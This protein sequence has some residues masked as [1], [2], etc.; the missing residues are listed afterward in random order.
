M[1]TL[2]QGGLTCEADYDNGCTVLK[3]GGELDLASAPAL[4][5][6]IEATF[7]EYGARLLIDLTALEFC[8][9]TGL[10]AL[11]GAVQ[12]A[13]VHAVDLRIIP[14]AA[15]AAM[16]AIE[17]SGG[18]EFLPLRHER[19]EHERREQHEVDARL[20]QGRVAGQDRQRGDHD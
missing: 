3:V 11:I 14:P 20:L 13:R 9:S 1:E 18:A 16:R 7:R 19:Q 5:A 12:E 6:R 2:S 17:I 15:P 10:R 4:T 8:D